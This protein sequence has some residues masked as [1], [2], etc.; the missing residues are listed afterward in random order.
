MLFVRLL[1]G[2]R[3]L[4]E[5]GGRRA[6]LQGCTKMHTYELKIEKLPLE[7]DIAYPQAGHYLA[8]KISIFRFLLNIWCVEFYLLAFRF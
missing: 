1:G 3:V 2:Y 6:W 4:G 8:E 5:N 7:A